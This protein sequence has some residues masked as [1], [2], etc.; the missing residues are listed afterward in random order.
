VFESIGQDVRSAVRTLGKN[1]RTTVLAIVTLG[2]GIGINAAI[3]TVVN[4]VLFRPLPFKDSHRLVW[5]W[6]VNARAPLKQRVSY[7][8]FLAWRAQSQTL[9]EL[10]GWNEYTPILTGLEQPQRVH[11]E[12]TIGNLFSVLGVPPILGTIAEVEKDRAQDPNVILSYSLW[13]GSFKSDPNVVGRRIT[14]DGIGYTVAAVMPLSFK[15]PIQSSSH[16]DIWVR[17]QRFNPVL[18]NRRDA[19]LIEVMGRLKPNVT[20]AQAQAE[21]DGIASRLSIQYP[22]TNTA[23]RAQIVPAIDEV[24]GKTSLLLLALFGGVACVLSIAC[25]NVANL[26][27][28]R[29]V[30]TRRELAVRAALGASRGRIARVLV[31]ESLLIGIGGGILGG[32]AAYSSLDALKALLPADIPRIMEIGIDLRVLGFTT[33]ISIVAGLLFGVAPGWYISTIDLN[34]SLSG[35]SYSRSKNRS[36]KTI[37]TW[38]VVGQIA[39]AMIL[40]TGAGLFAKSLWRL[41]QS[42][43]G[44]DPNGVLTFGISLPSPKYPTPGLAFQEIQ[45]RL[46]AI[47]GVRSA[48]VGLQLPD[49]GTPIASDIAPFFE[50]EGRQSPPGAR[51]R[52][53][54]LTIQPDYFRTM[55]IPLLKGRDFTANDSFRARPVI[56]INQSLARTY[57]PN[58]DPIG[59]H[60]TMD[61]WVVPGQ[62]TTPEI[63][64]IAGDVK[65][66]SVTSAQPLVYAAMSQFPRWGSAVVVKT[67]GDPLEI[68]GAV[69]EAIRSF[70]KDQPIDDVQ[71]LGQRMSQSIARERF[72]ALFLG[73]LSVV[74]VILA[75]VGLYGVLA[76]TVAQMTREISIRLA[77]GAEASAVLKLVLSYGL[78]VAATG[79]AIGTIGAMGLTRLIQTL[80]FGVSAADPF[81]FLFAGF[82]ICGIAAFASWIPARRAMKVDPIEALRCH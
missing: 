5:L 3:F 18:A 1:F 55:E 9:E 66:S 34:E 23:M 81:T 37:S 17:L 24:V 32:V 15:F 70:D 51:P 42:E 8:D 11:A 61:S 52:A 16:I 41:S 10:V 29:T 53:S 74:A 12:L 82:V 6:S 76:Y 25:V 39:I 14:L 13:Q 31:V 22:E 21:M 64:G 33:F 71:T 59:K 44:F 27:L 68:V 73:L 36:G 80:L 56:I 46:Q 72:N 35:I 67:A 28:A 45:G 26:H 4:S 62:K 57:F 40:V 79:I 20:V 47:P 77:I 38:L 54:I 30:A 50:I 19:R 43:S 69:R 2:V 63:I 65:H 48:S 78:K 75:A 7:P 58:E 60:L 49:R